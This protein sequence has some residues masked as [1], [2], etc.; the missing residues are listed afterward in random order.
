M[1]Y[2]SVFVFIIIACNPPVVENEKLDEDTTRLIG[3]SESIDT[4]TRKV[5]EVSMPCSE[6][7]VAE[8]IS[9]SNDFY[10]ALLS[11]NYPAA[12]KHLHPDALSVTS[13]DEWIKIYSSAQTKTGKM[14]FVKLVEQGAKCEFKGGNG[15]G[16]Y[17]E[18]IFE[19]Q[20]KDGD[21][22]EK[23]IFFRKDKTESLKILGYEYH[24]LSDRIILTEGLKGNK[25]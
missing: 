6:L 5:A 16:D 12:N 17:A 9:I 2:L 21:L 4:P 3:V 15:T 22:R 20:Y 13:V 23:L 11:Q 1:K 14:G 25:K 8:A 7:L 24:M 10:K 19:A 18:L